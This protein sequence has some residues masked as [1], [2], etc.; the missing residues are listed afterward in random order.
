ML[1]AIVPYSLLTRKILQGN[2]PQ[3]TAYVPDSEMSALEMGWALNNHSASSF[4]KRHVGLPCRQSEYSRAELSLRTSYAEAPI[5]GK[6]WGGR[7]FWAS[8]VP[9]SR[10]RGAEGGGYEKGAYPVLSLTHGLGSFDAP[11]VGLQGCVVAPPVC[12]QFV[13]WHNETLGH[14]SANYWGLVDGWAQRSKYW[15]ALALPASQSRRLW[16][17]IFPTCVIFNNSVK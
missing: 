4:C 5:R 10:R 11:S 7:Q 16:S 9:W 13:L 3:F 12:W 2:R 17:H 8:K 1:R 15:E 14:K 6:Y